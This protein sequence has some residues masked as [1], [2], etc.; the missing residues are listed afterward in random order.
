MRIFLKKLKNQLG[1]FGLF[2]WQLHTWKLICL[3]IVFANFCINVGRT[4]SKAIT[5]LVLPLCTAMVL[6]V[7]VLAMAEAASPFW[8]LVSIFFFANHRHISQIAS[9]V[10]WVIFVRWEPRRR[11]RENTL[12]QNV[13]RLHN[14]TSVTMTT[15]CLLFPSVW[16]VC[17]A[18]VRVCG[19]TATE[20]TSSWSTI[21]CCI[22]FLAEGMRDMQDDRAVTSEFR[23]V[24]YEDWSKYPVS[25][26]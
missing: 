20:M 22:G 25:I 3:K 11:S 6:I 14:C 8:A 9:M 17:L 7:V 19:R 16:P 13:G 18:C 26:D 4:C 12:N 21:G 1:H 2:W 15:S 24:R 23:R 10:Q 5:I